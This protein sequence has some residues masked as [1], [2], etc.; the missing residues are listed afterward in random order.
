MKCHR[1]GTLNNIYLF[2][3]SSGEVQDRGI[4]RVGERE[5]SSWL[6]DGHL[7]AGSSHGLS[8]V[9]VCRQRE[10]ESSLVSLLMRTLILLDKAPPLLP[11]IILFTSLVALSPDIATL[12]V[13]DSTY[14]F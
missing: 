12:E 13:R 3:H 9:H 1:L 8:S 7:L 14:E 5:L 4:G 2:S 10:R 6:S 11:Y